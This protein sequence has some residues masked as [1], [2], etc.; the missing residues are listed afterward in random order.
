MESKNNFQSDFFFKI[1]L[2]EMFQV[3][4]VDSSK[5]CYSCTCQVGT[6]TTPTIVKRSI[7]I[8][9]DQ[10][11]TMQEIKQITQRPGTMKLDT[12][13][14]LESQNSITLCKEPN[15]CVRSSSDVVVGQSYRNSDTFRKVPNYCIASSSNVVMG[16]SYHNSDTFCKEPNCA[17]SSSDAVLG[18]SYRSLNM[19]SLTS[20]KQ[21]V[22]STHDRRNIYLGNNSG[23]HL[24]KNMNESITK[25][26]EILKCGRNVGIL[27]DYTPSS[28]SSG[29]EKL[30]FPDSLNQG[31]CTQEENGRFSTTATAVDDHAVYSYAVYHEELESRVHGEKFMYAVESHEADSSMDT[32]VINDQSDK[33]EGGITF[34]NTESV[35]EEQYQDFQ[36]DNFDARKGINSGNRAKNCSFP[37][38]MDCQC[39]AEVSEYLSTQTENTHMQFQNNNNS[40][41]K[42]RCHTDY[43]TRGA[44]NCKTVT[45]WDLESSEVDDPTY[46][47]QLQTENTQLFLGSKAS[48]AD[49]ADLVDD[50]AICVVDNAEINNFNDLVDDS[51]ICVV[52][53]DAVD[54]FSEL[55]D[56][57]AISAVN[58]NEEFKN[59]SNANIADFVDDSAIHV[60]NDGETHNTHDFIGESL[61]Q[62]GKKTENLGMIDIYAS[63][64]IPGL[65]ETKARE[66]NSGPK[67]CKGQGRSDQYERLQRFVSCP[68]DFGYEEPNKQIRVQKVLDSVEMPTIAD[69]FTPVKEVTD[70]QDFLREEKEPS[71]QWGKRGGDNVPM[72]VHSLDRAKRD[73]SAIQVESTPNRR[74]GTDLHRL[75]QNDNIRRGFFHTNISRHE[76]RPLPVPPVCDLDLQPQG[77]SGLSRKSP[78]L[79]PPKVSKLS[80]HP[81]KLVSGGKT[82]RPML[83]QLLANDRLFVHYNSCLQG[84]PGWSP[85]ETEYT[86]SCGIVFLS[87]MQ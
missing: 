12:S 32:Q 16:Q 56:D 25:Q 35:T 29:S 4:K 78:P 81:Y 52:K 70:I 30:S 21:I 77:N 19:D 15:D 61:V 39:E 62:T 48:S 74:S 58:V 33:E 18:Q 51:A 36:G 26:K 59:A 71:R 85:R 1:Y 13:S 49:I 87:K 40:K 22:D 20:Q 75:R 79:L 10:E 50:S 84:Y 42:T 11:L 82:S 34:V 28:S 3:P 6:Q 69:S 54:N 9:D 41:K 47:E 55:V 64:V 73:R 27:V 7:T 44:K 8:Y 53:D 67:H 14:L 60:V 2:V 23:A 5:P 76:N 38:E 37:S 17:P 65:G 31:N 45:G 46:T 63:S 68:N 66:H 86:V 57:S 80:P 24:N 83:D 43:T 72:V